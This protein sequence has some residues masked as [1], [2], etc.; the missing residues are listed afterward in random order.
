MKIFQK[1]YYL[2]KQGFM[3]AW[4][5]HHSLKF[6][7]KEFKKNDNFRVL[8]HCN[9]AWISAPRRMEI[10]YVDTKL[11]Y[12][13]IEEHGDLLKW[14][15]L[16]KQTIVATNGSPPDFWMMVGQPRSPQRPGEWVRPR[17]KQWCWPLVIR[18]PKFKKYPKTQVWF[19]Y[20]LFN[21]KTVWERLT[22]RNLRSFPSRPS[23]INYER[24][25]K[26]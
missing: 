1:E 15:L 26:M 10:W 25:S 16:Q 19:Q 6:R 23:K 22:W 4:E 18:A 24:F 20:Q 12:V 13:C 5:I 14:S 8:P 21:G 2:E 9:I 17:R 11:W 3:K 7:N